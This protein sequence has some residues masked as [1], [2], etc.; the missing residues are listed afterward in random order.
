MRSRTKLIIYYVSELF[1]SIFLFLLFLV[2]ILKF[3]LFNL[4]FFYKQLDKNNYYE[5]LSDSIH[6]GMTNYVYQA[7][8]DESI[9]DGLYTEKSLKAEVQRLARNFYVGRKMSVNTD[10][11]E[12]KLNENIMKYIEDNNL[13]VDKQEDLDAFVDQMLQI[14]N[15][16]LILSDILVKMSGKFGK[17]NNVITI[18]IFGL[19]SLFLILFVIA[20]KACKKLLLPIPCLTTAF[21]ALLGNYLIFKQINVANI[22][23]WNVYVSKVIG[24]IISN[25]SLSVKVGS[26]ILI[27]IAFI[28]TIIQKLFIQPKIKVKQ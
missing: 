18:S 19:L 25:I 15:D 23:F 2:I 6:T 22:S 4:N 11:I 7:G 10:D 1:L 28:I 16:K 21:L 12:K 9:F 24:S 3:T 13:V 8:L 26:I 27:V 17:M 5:Q 14:Y 20:K